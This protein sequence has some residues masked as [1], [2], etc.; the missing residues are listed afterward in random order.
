MAVILFPCGGEDEAAKVNEKDEKIDELIE[1]GG[2]GCHKLCAK[3][4]PFWALSISLVAFVFVNV[5]V[6]S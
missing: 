4:E 1:E 3:R 2:N 5:V 6:A